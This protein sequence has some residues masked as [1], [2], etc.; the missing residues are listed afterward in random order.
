VPAE[1]S[2]SGG[3]LWAA[4]MQR[5]IGVSMFWHVRAVG[6]RLRLVTLIEQEQVITRILRHLGL[7]LT[8]PLR[9]RPP[10]V[11]VDPVDLEWQDLPAFAPRS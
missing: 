5:T 8:F 7:R 6:G 11:P 3:L 9:S 2:G 4:L 10:P 1:P